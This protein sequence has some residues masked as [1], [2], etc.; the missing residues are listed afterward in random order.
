M[1]IGLKTPPILEPQSDLSSLRGSKAATVAEEK[2]RLR[3]ASKEFESFFTYFMMKT[4]RKTIPESPLDEGSPFSNTM[5]KDIFTQMFDMEV[6]KTLADRERDSLGD[7]LFKSLEKSV[8]GQF[9]RETNR[10][11]IRPLKPGTGVAP[12]PVKRE[13]IAL[14]QQAPNALELRRNRVSQAPLSRAQHSPTEDIMSRYGD[15]IDQA[16]EATS[17]DS[18]LIAS[19]IKTES[20]GDPDAVSRAGAKG[21]MQLIDTTAEELG[22]ENV[23][24]PQENILAGSK[25]LKKMI[26]RFGDVKLGL[27]AYNA[28]PGNVKK[29]GGIPPFPETQQYVNKVTALNSS[30]SDE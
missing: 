12:V 14:P 18:T 19:V 11:E 30:A 9:N 3:K 13:P 24:N 26:D 7:M 1:S 17:L 20:N 5:G 27:A 8:E 6:S 23:Y 21:L 15:L 10:P 4:M 29:Y 2:A 25:Y 16:A 28:G 22:V